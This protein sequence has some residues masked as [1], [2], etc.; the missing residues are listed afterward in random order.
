MPQPFFNGSSDGSSVRGL[1][2]HAID[3]IG[4]GGRGKVKTVLPG[5]TICSLDCIP[6]FNGVGPDLSSREIIYMKIARLFGNCTSDGYPGI[7]YALVLERVVGEG[8]TFR[9]IGI[10]QIP[11]AD[12]MAEGRPTRAIKSNIRWKG[13]NGPRPLMSFGANFPTLHN[14]TISSVQVARIFCC[15]EFQY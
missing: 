14:A 10:A 12:G 4:T 11:D 1:G 8:E 5:Q 9:R 6:G 7:L 2:I 15:L 3:R 13:A